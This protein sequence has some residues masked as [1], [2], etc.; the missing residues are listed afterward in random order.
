MPNAVVARRRPTRGAAAWI[1]AA[2]VAAA[3]LLALALGPLAGLFYSPSFVPRVTFV[4]TTA[5]DISI[6]ATGA[7]RDGWLLVGTAQKN[8]TTVVE[9]T[10]DQGDVWIFRFS[11][12]GQ[13]VGEVKMTRDELEQAKWTVQ[14]P[15]S[16][17]AALR[18]AGAPPSP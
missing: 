16:I 12:Q 10:I 14:I 11:G 3:V 8:S 6:D 17:G 13:Q 9:G 2:L 1:A 7:E 5:Y 15:D 4:N 18:A